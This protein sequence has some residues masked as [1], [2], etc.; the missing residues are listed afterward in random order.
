MENQIDR[1]L[2]LLIETH[3]SDLHISAG[4]VPQMRIHGAITPIE[5]EPVWES[6]RVL[7]LLKEIMPER[8][9][10]EL[11]EEW[12][13]DC[14]YQIPGLARFRVNGFRDM[15]GFGTVLRQIPEKIPTFEELNL[16]P[17]IRDFCYLTKGLV[18]VTGPTGSGKSTTLSAIIDNINR[19]RNEHIIT[20]EDPVEFVHK[21]QKCLINQREVHRDTESFA[22][23]LR[24]ALR[25]DPD[26]VLVGEMRDLETMETAIETAE[27]GHL[28]FATLHTNTAA[29][30]V[31]RM[32]DKFPAERQN[33]IRSMLADTLK[34]VVAQTL[35]R[36][37]DGKG[38]AAAFEVLVVNT[39]V[40]ALIREAKTHMLPSVLQTGRKEG[41]QTF[42]DELTRLAAKGIISEEEAYNKAVDKV[43]IE[44]KFKMA[45][46]SM[47]FKKRAEQED[48]AR[49]LERARGPFDQIKQAWETN[50]GDNNALLAY[51]W[52][53]A[54]SPFDELRDG[55]LALKLAERGSSALRDRDPYALTVVAAARA[56]NGDFRKAADLSRKAAEL[57]EKNGDSVKAAAQQ[58][59]IALFEK[60]MPF[61]DE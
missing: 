28:V 3:G 6:D 54:T 41:M 2:R 59:R 4:R 1:F 8:N 52:A 36:R 39:S 18:V 42:G 33:Q 37:R 50:A 47:D 14:A 19:T 55:K 22:R 10:K 44:T 24:A 57:Y 48:R 16:P 5:G 38:R 17:A 60:N 34:G 32:I 31:E 30:T 23:A 58:P 56:E 26:I 21:P 15:N 51:A 25:E 46:V 45:G 29:S 11:V 7:G 20:I 27:T 35:C 9:I 12:D 13:T 53:L 40:A 61:R 43:E 49:R